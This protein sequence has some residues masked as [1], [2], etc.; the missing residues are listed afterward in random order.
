MAIDKVG[1][2]PVSFGNFYADIIGSAKLASKFVDNPKL[3]EKFFQNIVEPLSHTKK[4]NVF[5]EGERVGIINKEGEGVMRIIEPGS[6]VNRTLGVVYDY[7]NNY[8][9]VIRSGSQ[10]VPTHI[11]ENDEYFLR[12][13]EAAKNIIFDR[14]AIANVNA[15]G[16]YTKIAEETQGQKSQRFAQM[17]KYQ[18]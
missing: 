3:E 5:V 14:E 18:A 4:Y 16:L 6:S 7:E 9:N 13:I 8:R 10:V 17:F 2:S 1:S 15:K 12:D 11:F